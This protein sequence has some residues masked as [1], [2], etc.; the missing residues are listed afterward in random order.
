MDYRFSDLIVAKSENN[1]YGR[2]VI[3]LIISSR[4]RAFLIMNLV[5]ALLNIPSKSL[6][7]TYRIWKDAN[8]SAA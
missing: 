6:M 1:Y 2:N 5:N 7:A 4:K 8:S 3:G